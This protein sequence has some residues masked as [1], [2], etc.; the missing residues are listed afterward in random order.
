VA[1]FLA[2]DNAPEA[3]LR[4][5][6]QA[7]SLPVEWR[8]RIVSR[9]ADFARGKKVA[10]PDQPNSSAKKAIEDVL[11]DFLTDTADVPADFE[12]ESDLVG[13]GRVCDLAEQG[14][15]ELWPQRYEF[16][17]WLSPAARAR[18]CVAGNNVRAQELGEPLRPLPPEAPQRPLDDATKDVVSEVVIAPPLNKSEFGARL[19]TLRG[20]PLDDKSLIAAIIPAFSGPEKIPRGFALSISRFHDAP[21]ITIQLVP[22]AGPSLEAKDECA[23]RV[24]FNGDARSSS[25]GSYSVSLPFDRWSDPDFWHVLTAEFER[26]ATKR[27]KTAFTI[28]VRFDLASRL[29]FPNLKFVQN[30]GLPDPPP[31]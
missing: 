4:L 22:L 23:V 3:S 30:G 16:D 27:P 31:N 8:A 9:L 24:L 6:G 17:R 25:H 26:P 20:A 5:G 21:G 13:A 12:F 19:A 1:D 28:G 10:N 7:A 2:T 15:H 18:Q 29:A 14:L 11:R